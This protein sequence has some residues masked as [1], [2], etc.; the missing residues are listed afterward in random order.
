MAEEEEQRR[1][2]GNVCD[3]YI[4]SIYLLYNITSLLP[5]APLPLRPN[6]SLHACSRAF[7]LS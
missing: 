5:F 3:I 7:F 6:S 2:D 4:V 1:Q